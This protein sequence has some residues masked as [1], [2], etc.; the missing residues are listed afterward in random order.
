MS[1]RYMEV[2]VIGTGR[3]IDD[4]IVPPV[5]RGTRAWSWNYYFP[6]PGTPI[7]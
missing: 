5:P 3:G 2:G 7:T 6:D 4:I 1:T